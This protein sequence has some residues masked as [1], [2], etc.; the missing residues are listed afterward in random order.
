MHFSLYYAAGTNLFLTTRKLLC[1]I[2]AW[3]SGYFIVEELPQNLSTILFGESLKSRPKNT[4]PRCVWFLKGSY[5]ARIAV[6]CLQVK[7]ARH[8]QE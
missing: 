3:S 1:L 4:E 5:L 2:E 8:R 7:T 6:S